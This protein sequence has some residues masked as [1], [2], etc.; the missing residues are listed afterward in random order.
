NV[1][2]AAVKTKG[3][4]VDPPLELQIEQI[5][6]RGWNLDLARHHSILWPAAVLHGEL[7]RRQSDGLAASAIDVRLKEQVGG[8][9]LGLRRMDVSLSVTQQQFG[10][11]RSPIFIRDVQLHRY[12]RLHVKQNRYLTAKA[13]VLVALLH[14]KT[15]CRLAL[16][17]LVAINQ[18]DRIL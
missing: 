12:R 18:P 3:R 13:K 4:R 16:A 15:N 2:V 17:S 6:S 10:D 14:V 9:A 1:V 5:L 11:C 8:D 7:A